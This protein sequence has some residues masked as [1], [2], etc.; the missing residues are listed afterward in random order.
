MPSPEGRSHP[1]STDGNRPDWSE[2]FRP[3]PRVTPVRDGWAS[4]RLKGLVEADHF[5]EPV[6]CHV[7]A[8]CLPLRKAPAHD[9]P[10]DTQVLFGEDL[11]LLREEGDWAWVQARAD[12][13][14]GF[15]PRAGLGKGP[16]R[17][18]A[19]VGVLR[20]FVFSRPDLKSPP[21][22]MLSLNA[23]V[24]VIGARGQ[25]SAIDQSLDGQ[26]PDS[27][28][29]YIFTPHLRV[30]EQWDRDPA[31]CA[32]RFLGAPYLWG[33]KDSLG[34][35]CSGLVQMALHACGI[36]SPRDADMQEATLGVPVG[37][38]VEDGLGQLRRGD[39]IF[40]KGHVT[41]M[42]DGTHMVHANAT[43][44]AVTI[45]P[46]RDFAERIACTDG[47]VRSVRRLS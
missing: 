14:V 20:T 7:T 43:H 27:R 17:A 18:G 45:D 39:L 12:D 19:R 37:A 40:W 42:V 35:D 33:G 11:D 4:A 31:G 46:L 34:L 26:G 6:L 44:M 8:P 2:R 28:P 10:L 9:A 29:G 16:A 1:T 5:A 22:G 41:M 36:P 47:P 38:S 21:L 15:V 32:E 25:F 23:R 24:R 13:Y 3:D 30:A